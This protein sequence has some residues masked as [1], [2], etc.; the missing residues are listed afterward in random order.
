MW[1]CAHKRECEQRTLKAATCSAVQHLL[2]GK[3]YGHKLV[4]GSVEQE[5]EELAS[6]LLLVQEGIGVPLG[7][8]RQAQ[9]DVERCDLVALW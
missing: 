3:L 6:V 4:V 9:R 2:R 5:G 1:S 7:R 8:L